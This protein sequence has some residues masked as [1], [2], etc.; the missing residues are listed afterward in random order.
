MRKCERL[1]PADK[2]RLAIEYAALPR[3]GKSLKIESGYVALLARK[4]GLSR[5]VV[6]NIVK[7]VKGSG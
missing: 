3:R 2:R 6:C 1:T 5:T 7:Q 4:W